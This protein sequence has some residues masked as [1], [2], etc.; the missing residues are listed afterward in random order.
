MPWPHLRE[1]GR[2]NKNMI[3]YEQALSTVLA[4]AQPLGTDSPP[5]DKLSG[6]VLAEPVL[7][8][9]DLP[10]FNN[11]AVD[12]FGVRLTDVEAASGENPARLK[13]LG[14][15]QAGDSVDL[16]LQQGTAVKI[17]TGAPIPSEVEAVIMQE[18][19]ESVNGSV[20]LIQGAKAGE[21]IRYRGEEY[22]SGDVVLEA[23]TVISPPVIGLL[24]SLGYGAAKVYRK[25]RISILITGNEL[26]PPGQP[27]SPGRIYES[28]SYSLIS[29][30][31][32]MGLDV[33]SVRTAS[34]QKTDLTVAMAGALEVS[35]IV[36]S[37]GGVSV[38]EFDLVK[39]IAG[40]LDIETL[41]WKVAIK[42]GKPVFFGIKREPA[43]RQKLIFGLPGNPV[44]V[45]VT[46]HL[47]IRP[48]L[49]QMTGR[50][51]KSASFQ[52]A[53]LS[54]DLRKKPGR[55]DF[56]RGKLDVGGDQLAVTP[57]KGQGSHML[58]GLAQADCLILFPQEASFLAAETIVD[59]IPL[60]WGMG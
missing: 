19:S 25:P 20:S 13:L 56:V 4:H 51:G 34:D 33:V 58:G 17:L 60:H 28:N 5:L 10:L 59:I 21:N 27:L 54:A 39:D 16:A 32:A 57:C 31:Q 36:I 44:A 38:G 2:D 43:T 37:T 29:A 48:L 7:A 9:H 6:M 46:F 14:T 15:I 1:A 49:L 53:C 47:F 12:G 18:F 11:S 40:S 22:R 24:A 35:D 50:K 41:F 52:K 3:T 8:P 26:L 45:L 30:L 55:L 42:P 23:N